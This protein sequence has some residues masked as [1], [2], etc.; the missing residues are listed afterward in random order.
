LKLSSIAQKKKNI[1]IVVESAGYGLLVLEVI[2]F[3]GLK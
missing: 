1:G 3:I 2:V